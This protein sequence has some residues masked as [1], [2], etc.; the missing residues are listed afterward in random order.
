M[1]WSSFVPL[2]IKRIESKY[3]VKLTHTKWQRPVKII[4]KG[5]FKILV[6]KMINDLNIYFKIRNNTRL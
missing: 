2:V 3:S 6:T 4:I 5:A 1:N